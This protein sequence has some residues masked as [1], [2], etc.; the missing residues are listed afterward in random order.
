MSHLARP[1]RATERPDTVK[2]SRTGSGPRS[3]PTRPASWSW[4]EVGFAEARRPRRAAPRPPDARR[5]RQVDGR[6]QIERPAFWTDVHPGDVQHEATRILTL[7]RDV[8]TRGTTESGTAID[9][10][11]HA[12]R[13]DP[14]TAGGRRAPNPHRR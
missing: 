12:A 6:G 4:A 1:G 7:V 13:F 3:R 14:G 8:E 5:T 9:N 11:A 10:T 2:S